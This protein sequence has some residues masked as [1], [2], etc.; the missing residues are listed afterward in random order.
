MRR[1]YPRGD[2]CRQ[3]PRGAVGASRSPGGTSRRP[4]AGACVGGSVERTVRGASIAGPAPELPGNWIHTGELTGDQPGDRAPALEAVVEAEQERP[5]SDRENDGVGDALADEFIGEACGACVEERIVDVRGVVE[6]AGH[7][8][9]TFGR[10]V[11]RAGD[12]EKP[13]TGHTNLGHNGST[14]TFRDYDGAFHPG[15]SGVGGQ[16]GPGVARRILHHRAHTELFEYADHG[17]GPAVLERA[18]WL[19][20]LQLAVVLSTDQ[21]DGNKRRE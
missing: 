15:R 2:P 10:E 3:T 1:G 7:L 11:A 18:R 8:L 6:L 16:C 13:S 9:G 17:L 19:A 14:G 5:V 12:T 20:K 4:E 21:C